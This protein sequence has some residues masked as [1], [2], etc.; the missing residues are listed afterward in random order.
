MKKAVQFGAGNIGRGF[1]GQLFNQ[2]GYEIVFVELQKDVIAYLNREHSYKLR[3]VGENPQELVID[4]VRA[5]DGRDKFQVGRE[6]KEA[7]IMATAVGARNLSSIS[8]LVAEGMR[9]RADAKVEAP[10]NLILCENL[11]HAS[12]V[13][14]EYL[15]EEIN[16]GYRDYLD[17]H[18]GLVE[19]VVSRMVPVIPRD[20]RKKDPTFIMVEEYSILPVDKKGFK[21]KIPEIKGMVPYENLYA[22]EEQKLFIHNAGHAICA[23]LGHLKGYEYIW[24]AIEDEEVYRIVR[25]GLEE[26]GAALIKKHGFTQEEQRAHIEDLL[27][28]FANH[29][30]S[31]TIL[32]V[33]RDPIRK[34]GPQERLIGAAKLAYR[35]GITPENI[36]RGIAAALLF[37][38]EEDEEARRLSQMRRKE[39]VDAILKKIC[40]IDP[41]GPLGKLI[42]RNLDIK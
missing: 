6:I 39:G 24:Q 38:V 19:S 10:V 9:Q 23:Y 22:Y 15:L 12:K 26:T 32:R 13:F 28:R 7:D 1:L 16:S 42:K 2:S 21:G 4:R 14:K 27:K 5:V 8:C 40:Q 20:M 30:L 29:A 41:E 34:L 37:D 25:A 17:S 3:I 35:Y 31:D 11:P 18:L 33:G 36:A